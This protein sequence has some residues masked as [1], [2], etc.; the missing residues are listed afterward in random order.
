MGL[1]RDIF[2]KKSEEMLEVPVDEESKKPVMVRIETLRDFVDIDRI[3]R[4]LK[5]G[6]IVFLKTRDLQKKDLGEFQNSVQKLKRISSQ[7]G[8]DIAGTEEGYIV[9]TPAFAK[10]SREN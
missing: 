10:I 7:Q 4:L 6:S 2:S 8:F 3:T 1:L 5:D 9:V